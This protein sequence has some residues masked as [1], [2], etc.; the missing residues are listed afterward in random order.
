MI[1][2]VTK[3]LTLSSAHKLEGHPTCGKIHGHNY[4]VIVHCASDKHEDMVADLNFAEIKKLDHDYLNNFIPY[5]TM[6]N[7]AKYIYEKVGPVCRKVEIWETD[8]NYC[9]Y[10]F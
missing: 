9:S 2:K 6:E 1:T 5:P 8:N 4:R 7:L 3:T 10:E